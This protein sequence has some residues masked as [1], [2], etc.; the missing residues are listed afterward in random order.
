VAD[1]E[2][3]YRINVVAQKTGISAA[4]LRAWERRYGIPVPRRTESS[5]R[6]YSDEDIAL[7]QRLRS[8]CNDGM[9]PSE[10][11]KVVLAEAQ[12][13]IAEPGVGD[14]YEQVR[15]QIVHAVDEF[16]PDGIEMS[17][18]RALTL[19]SASVIC[20]RVIVP[21]MFR[22]GNL[23]HSGDITIAQEHLATQILETTARKL[24]G[25]MQPPPGARRVLLACFAEDEHTLPLYG[26]ALHLVQASFRT[27]MLGSRT[28]PAAI[29]QTVQKLKPACVGLS[30]TMPPPPHRARELVDA[31][32]DACG[33][34]PWVVG[35]QAARDLE[36]LVEA[37]G[38][39]VVPHDDVRQAIRSIESSIARRRRGP[40]THSN[41]G[42]Q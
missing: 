26:I 17:V 15:N 1:D 9:S 39:S 22:I 42:T 36:P 14:P 10:A 20:E 21:V 37:R 8:L 35:G 11:A 27:V 31:Y 3:K 38:G 24:I 7:I 13:P 4:T 12:Q 29:R 33:D 23:W 5:Y 28:P 6:V 19:G 41:K 30:V 32:A 2:G 40:K 34:T 18:N 16:D 25:L